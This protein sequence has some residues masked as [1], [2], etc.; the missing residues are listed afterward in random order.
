MVFQ[1][2]TAG[3]GVAKFV[4]GGVVS[5]GTDF[6]LLRFE[7][8]V[9]QPGFSSIVQILIVAQDLVHLVAVIS[10]GGKDRLTT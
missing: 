8:H 4:E 1:V 10:L 7:D 9:A 6:V 5:V 2:E 3:G